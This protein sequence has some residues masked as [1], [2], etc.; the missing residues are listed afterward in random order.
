MVNHGEVMQFVGGKYQGKTGWMNSAKPETP[1]CYYVYVKLESSEKE[2]RVRKE[3]VRK[4]A[5]PIAQSYEEAVLVQHTDID[6]MVDKLVR[7]LAK[8]DLNSDQEMGRIFLRKLCGA[9]VRQATLG[10]K[11]LWRQVSFDHDK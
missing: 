1:M 6:R 9:S 10:P 8:C 2:T 7:K 4:E 11:A 3:S 5:A